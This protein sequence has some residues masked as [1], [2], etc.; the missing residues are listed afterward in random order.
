VVA[1]VPSQATREQV[2][3]QLAAKLRQAE[4]EAVPITQVVPPGTSLTRENIEQ[5]L[6]Q[7]G[8]DGLLISRYKRTTEN[9]NYVPGAAWDWGG[10]Y[11]LYGPYAAGYWTVT[12]QAQ[13]ETSLFDARGEK[14]A[15]IWSGT[16]ATAESGAGGS[17]ISN[18]DIAHYAAVIVGR[19]N[20]DVRG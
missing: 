14:G 10:Y 16:S 18:Q 12:P 20:K 7:G 9:V 2:Q 17:T 6:R 1:F 4:V 15:L 5:A 3:S 13:M 11:S 8:F 19:L